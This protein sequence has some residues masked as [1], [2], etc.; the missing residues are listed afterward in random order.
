M[1]TPDINLYLV[2]FMGTGK[3][4][5]GRLLV[6]PL[7]FQFLD[8]DHEIERQQ[9]KPISRIFAEDGEARFRELEREFIQRGH[10]DHGCIVA[11]GGGLVV[12][13]GMLDLLRSRGVVICLHAPLETILRRTMHATHRPLFEVE[14]REQRVRELFAEREDI[15]RRTGTMVLT[16]RRP[17]R[18]IAAHVLRVYR[19]EAN[20]FKG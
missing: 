18:E 1:T 13:P 8:S 10:P 6:K 19:L 9:G 14:N 5:V 20:H 12:P 11:C 15:Y 16:D 4:T 17:M 7:G 3:S 2:G